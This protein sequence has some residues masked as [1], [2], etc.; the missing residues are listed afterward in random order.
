MTEQ[1]NADSES[2]PMRSRGSILSPT[3]SDPRLMVLAALLIVATLVVSKEWNLTAGLA[4][5]LIAM[6]ACL[7]MCALGLCMNRTSSGSCEN[8]SPDKKGDV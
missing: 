7:V 8:G 3:L 1:Q 4:P 2:L 5:I 6:L